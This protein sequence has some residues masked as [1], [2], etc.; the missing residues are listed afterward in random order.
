MTT[1]RGAIIIGGQRRVELREFPIPEPGPG[2]VL[3]RMKAAGM[4][5]SDLHN[6]YRTMNLDD[7]GHYRGCIAGH[8][9]AGTVE[10]VGPDCK[11][12]FQ[13]GDRV[14]VY[15]ICGCGYCNSCRK[16]WI[17]NCTSDQRS[18]YGWH[19][20]GAYA[21]YMLAEEYTLLKLPESLSFMDGA[22]ISCGFGTSFQ[23]VRRA[24][25]SGYDTVLVVGLGPVGL[26]A[27]IIA[28]AR[29]AR[30]IGVDVSAD[31]VATAER[32]GC[33]LGLVAD[34]TTLAAIREYTDGHGVEASIE[35]SAA[36]AGRMLAL[37][38]ARLWGRVVFL[39]EH[40]NL[41]FNPSFTVV[42]KQLTVHGS[43]MS[44]ISE[45]EDTIEHIVR[46]K[47]RPEE[48]V[49]HTFPITQVKEAFELADSGEAGKVVFVWE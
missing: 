29:G 43:W 4:C 42:Q 8:E 30:V 7:P 27:A 37:E 21:D 16:G 2:Q 28:K 11:R 6:I 15:H 48:I 49:T 47:L 35:C 18:V 22:I 41:S 3:L 40:G 31:R 14:L 13:R 20:D 36:Q 44:G 33:D 9:P 12:G 26:A 19:R 32:S 23:G 39:G 1:M 38:A 45:M 46:W 17:V 24:N 34:E 25:V 5:G 10:A